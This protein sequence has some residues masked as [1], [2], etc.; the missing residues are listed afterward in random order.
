MQDLQ[1][2]REMQQRFE[3]WKR[4]RGNAIDL[5]VSVTVL[6]T[7]YWPTYK[8]VELVLP[9]EMADGIQQFRVCTPFNPDDPIPDLKV[10][11]RTLTL[12]PILITT[13]TLS[14]TLIPRPSPGSSFT[15]TYLAGRLLR[16]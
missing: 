12:N 5:D 15:Q 7:G 9:K 14:Q 3:D 10:T 6:T 2:A 1:L 16:S 13:L 11:T 4:E 8:A